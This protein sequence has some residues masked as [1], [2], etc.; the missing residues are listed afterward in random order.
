MTRK[1]PFFRFEIYGFIH[2]KSLVA[3]I[4]FVQKNKFFAYDIEALGSNILYDVGDKKSFASSLKSIINKCTI[5]STKKP[6]YINMP[7]RGTFETLLKYN[8]KENRPVAIERTLLQ[9]K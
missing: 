9:C 1:T 6:I 7:V 5:F 8:V 2:D 4:R 3:I